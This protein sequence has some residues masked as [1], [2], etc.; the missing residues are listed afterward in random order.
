MQIKLGTPFKEAQEEQDLQRL[1]LENE[2]NDRKVEQ[3]KKYEKLLLDRKKKK[4]AALG[5]TALLTLSLLIFGTY[6]TFFK[7]QLKPQEVVQIVQTN[8]PNFPVMGLDGFV[9]ANFEKWF[10][11]LSFIQ[12]GSQSGIDKITPDLNSLTIDK[13]A[14]TNS[15]FSRV[16]FSLDI[17]VAKV[18]KKDD[19][20]KVLPAEKLKNRYGFQIMVSFE[21]NDKEAY[22]YH[23]VEKIAVQGLIPANESSPKGKNNLIA[24]KSERVPEEVS[25]KARIKVDKILGDLYTGRDV[26]QDF[27]NYFD[28]ESFGASYVSLDTFEYYTEPNALGFNA[29]IEYTI[30]TK[31]GFRMTST[32]YIYLVESGESF[33]IRG[34]S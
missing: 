31:E 14:E 22:G 28:F 9:R 17:E 26:S 23:L 25:Q 29:K 3:K 24:F 19:K 13:V 7:K 2:I 33:V 32:N 20:G 6:N 16:T 15:G 4:W 18:E 27:F 30:E 21:P 10:E 11:E 1:E 8:I 34:W 5:V 12:N